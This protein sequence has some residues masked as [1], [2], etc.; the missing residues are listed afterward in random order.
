MACHETLLIICMD[1]G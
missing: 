1:S